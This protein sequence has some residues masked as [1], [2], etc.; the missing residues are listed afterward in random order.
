MKRK[1]FKTEEIIKILRSAEASDLTIEEFCRQQ[2]I[3]E[4]SYYRWKQKYGSMEPSEAKRLKYLE[5]ENGRLKKLTIPKNKNKCRGTNCKPAIPKN[6]WRH[7]KQKGQ[8]Q[9]L[10]A[11]APAG[12]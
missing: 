1:R 4:Q 3:S 9:T 2:N 8:A 10:G 7:A 11:I 5:D 6:R 12:V